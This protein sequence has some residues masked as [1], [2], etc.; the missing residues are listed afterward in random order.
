[1]NVAGPARVR[2]VPLASASKRGSLAFDGGAGS[3]AADVNM[4]NDIPSFELS[5]DDFEEYALARLKVG[6]LS[7]I[8]VGI[9]FE[10]Q[11]L[12]HTRSVP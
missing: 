9:A 12:P 11:V 7:C 10:R 1:M 2:S 8:F 5:L 3:S 4:Y 6:L